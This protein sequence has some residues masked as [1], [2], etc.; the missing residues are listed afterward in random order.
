[1]V[2]KQSYGDM[3]K[4]SNI[5]LKEKNNTGGYSALA[6]DMYHAMIKANLRFWLSKTSRVTSLFGGNQNGYVDDLPQGPP[7]SLKFNNNKF[8]QERTQ[9]TRLKSLGLKCT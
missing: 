7:L 4:M 1:M 5:F 8:K 3:S 9:W 6:W 2:N